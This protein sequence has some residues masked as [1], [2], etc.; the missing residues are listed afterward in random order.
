MCGIAAMIAVGGGRADAQVVEAMTQSIRHRGPDDAGSYVCGPVGFGFRRLA[1]LDLTPTGHQPMQS[2]DGRLVLMFNGE[3]Y[4]YLELREELRALGHLF[5]STGD[6]QVLLT[7]YQ[8][9]GPDCL[10]RLNGMWAFLIYDAREGKIFGSRDRFGVKP[11]YRYRSGDFV[12]FASEIK[13]ILVTKHYRTQLRWD[14]IARCVLEPPLDQLDLGDD[15]FFAGI[16]QVPAGAAFELYL[17]GRSREWRFWRIADRVASTPVDAAPA[18]LRAVFEDAVRVRMRSDVPVSIS[19]SGGLDSTAIICV[20]SELRNRKG[21]TGYDEALQAFS[22]L[23]PEFDE[24]RYIEDTTK[25]TG[26]VCHE[27]DVDPRRLW[28]SM[29]RVL[30][31]QD[32]P[33]HAVNALVGFEIFGLAAREGLKV[34]LHGAGS[35]ECLGGYFSY[36]WDYW[37][38]LLVAGRTEEARSQIAAYCRTHGGEPATMHRR[39]IRRLW[40]F[41]L[42]ALPG[43]RSLARERHR[44]KLRRTGWFTREITEALPVPAQRDAAAAGDHLAVALRTSMERTPLPYYLRLDDRNSM[45]HSIELRCPFL[46]YRVVNLAFSLPAE[47]KVRGPWN[48]YVLREAMRGRIPES[49][50]TRPDKMGFPVPLGQWVSGPLYSTLQDMLS[51]Q[52]MRQRGIYHVRA[53]Q[54]DLE[55]HKAGLDDISERLFAVAQLE[56]WFRRRRAGP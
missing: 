15:T 32:E 55:R 39:L 45:A 8:Q 27:V 40:E 44:R 30:W 31:Y 11:L 35:D 53:I 43:Y 7:A 9:W 22:Y 14:H 12:F 28:D 38:T 25:W 52:E 46:D 54:R 26:A 36:F 17:D 51:S 48:K 29:E 20:V 19:L 4:N 47:W 18:V 10:S 6:A 23:A 1:I 49:V 5:T 41:K 21:S 16:E 13:A 56:R 2:L 3:I 50:R 34:M 37:F 33:V 42:A 24:R